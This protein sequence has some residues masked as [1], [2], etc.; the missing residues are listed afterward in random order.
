M[1]LSPLVYESSDGGEFSSVT[2]QRSALQYPGIIATVAKFD[3]PGSWYRAGWLSLL[4]NYGSAAPFE[5]VIFTQQL[6]INEAR[7]IMLPPTPG[8][9]TYKLRF[10]PVYW[11]GGYVI[12]I[13]GVTE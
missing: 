3:V 9:A 10:V 2:L 5:A 13:E 11:L 6:G 4:G 12:S 1:S 7:L 8:V